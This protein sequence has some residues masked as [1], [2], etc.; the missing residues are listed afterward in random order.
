MLFSS[1]L[2]CVGVRASR[3]TRCGEPELSEGHH[4]RK[5]GHQATR[6]YSQDQQTPWT[7]VTPG[8]WTVFTDKERKGRGADTVQNV[9]TRPQRCYRI[10]LSQDHCRRRG[11]ELSPPDSV[12]RG[13]DP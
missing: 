9:E 5:Q 3:F 7:T 2:Y 11:G 12:H 4:V 10:S 13:H 8:K 6:N 1:L